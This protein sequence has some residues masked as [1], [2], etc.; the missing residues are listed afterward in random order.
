MAGHARLTVTALVIHELD[1]A[2]G[3]REQRREHS[4]IGK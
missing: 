3:K 1:H 2:S 4:L